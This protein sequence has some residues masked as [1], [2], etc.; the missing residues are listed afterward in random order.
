VCRPEGL[1]G[2]RQPRATARGI[3]FGDGMSKIRVA[4]FID[5]FNVYHAIDELRAEHLKWVNLRSL[6]EC[7]IDPAAHEIVSVF[8]FTAHAEWLIDPCARH[9]EY[10]NALRHYG[11]TP[12][13][14]SFKDKPARCNGCGATWTAHEEKQSD[15]NIAVYMLGEAARDQFDQA[16]LVT[17]DSDLVPAVRL[18]R[19]LYP[20]K[21]V[22]VIAPPGRRH[23]K[24]LWAASTHRAA[25]QR[26]HVE[27]CL[28]PEEVCDASGTVIA[29]RPSKYDPP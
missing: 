29:R 23:S 3:L 1:T 25:I 15:V 17:R 7:F 11:V 2:P 8:Y 4:C 21:R 27:R 19:E 13:L 18:V 22:K 28:M 6:M 12:V 9:K 10:V 20:E 5:G 24:E 14:G 26:V 16:F